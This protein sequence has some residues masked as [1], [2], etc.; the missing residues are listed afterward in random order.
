[1]PYKRKVLISKG[2]Q[3]TPQTVGEHILKKR[4]EDGA[5]RKVL[6]SRFQVDEFTVMN[7]ELGRTKTVPV[8]FMPL[9]LE[10]LGYNP[11]PKPETVG[12]Q[13]RWK[14]RSLGW[15]TA[16]AAL[17][18]SVDQS[19]WEAWEKLAA[20]PK[21]PRFQDFLQEFLDMPNEQLADRIRRVRN[22]SPRRGKQINHID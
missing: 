5:T 11:E 14:R 6:A 2:F 8:A 17:R 12:E 18:N 7:W 20:W 1:M 3:G 13:L 22:P 16:E 4:L 10:Y 15:T 19:T 21:Y 9:V